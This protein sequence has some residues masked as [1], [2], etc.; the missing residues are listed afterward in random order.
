MLED[1]RP[2]EMGLHSLLAVRVQM[3]F[4]QIANVLPQW[5]PLVPFSPC[6]WSLKLRNLI[7][8]LI[9]KQGLKFKN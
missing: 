8:D 6:V 5:K 9:S 4:G 7:R 2:H 3:P 1:Y